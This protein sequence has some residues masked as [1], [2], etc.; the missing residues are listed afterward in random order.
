MFFLYLRTFSMVHSFSIDK[1]NSDTDWFTLLLKYTA[2]FMIFWIV[3]WF[4]VFYFITKE[5]DPLIEDSVF[6]NGGLMSAL[7]AAVVAAFLGYRA[8]SKFRF[9]SPFAFH[10][11]D[12]QSTLTIRLVNTLNNKEREMIIPYD[13]LR[14]TETDREDALF[15]KQRIIDIHDRSRLITSFNIELTAWVRHPE[16][17]TLVQLFM[18]FGAMN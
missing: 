12:D 5:Q 9:G 2:L 8:W 4:G 18:K 17:D 16:L 14:I 1:P 11:N 7:I 15:G 6:N 13:Y 3:A 10:F